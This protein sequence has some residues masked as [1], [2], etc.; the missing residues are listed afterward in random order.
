MSVCDPS[1]SGIDY[2]TTFE[3]IKAFTCTFVNPADLATVALLVWAG[4]GAA[5]YARQGSIV[6]PTILLLLTG[7]AVIST[8]AAPAVGMAGFLVLVVPAGIVAYAIYRYSR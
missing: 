8:L 4:I 5:I 3:F 6:M 1:V 2:L 7:G